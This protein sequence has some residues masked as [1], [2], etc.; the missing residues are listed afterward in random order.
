[1]SAFPY[2]LKL[3]LTA[4]PSLVRL[5]E[6]AA[7]AEGLSIALLKLATVTELRET[8]VAPSAGDTEETSGWVTVVNC[9]LFGATSEVPA[10]SFAVAFTVAV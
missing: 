4:A 1:M 2:Q 9:Q 7:S 6:K 8:P 5:S 3:P 10:V